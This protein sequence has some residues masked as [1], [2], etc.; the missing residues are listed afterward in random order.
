MLLQFGSMGQ[1]SHTQK[2][3]HARHHVQIGPGLAASLLLLEA[4]RR[5][6]PY[7]SGPGLAASLLLLE[8]NAQLIRDMQRPG[9]AASLLLLEVT[10]A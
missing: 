8:D 5:L 7:K 1:I 9:L 4:S 10:C 6:A 3:G 2:D